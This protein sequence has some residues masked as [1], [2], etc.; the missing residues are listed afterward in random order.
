MS[1]RSERFGRVALYSAVLTSCRS[2]EAGELQWNFSYN[3]FTPSPQV[4]SGLNQAA[5]RWSANLKT[6]GAWNSPRLV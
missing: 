4:V 6:S 5:A 3:G 1:V 2:L